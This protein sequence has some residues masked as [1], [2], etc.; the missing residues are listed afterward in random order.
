MLAPSIAAVKFDLPSTP[1]QR[2]CSQNIDEGL[3]T[4]WALVQAA[5]ESAADQ[6]QPIHE[7]EETAF[8]QLLIV[9]RWLLQAFLDMAGSGDV[10]PTMVVAGDSPDDPDREL[11][12]LEQTHTRPYLSI[13]GEINIDTCY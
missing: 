1:E 7:V 13:F 8:R 9:G 12:R 10:G 2:A 3:N 6:R 11:P 4:F 5:P